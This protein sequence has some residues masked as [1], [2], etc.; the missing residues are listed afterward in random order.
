[1][2]FIE[3]AEEWDNVIDEMLYHLHYMDEENVIKELEKD[4]PDEWNASHIV[5]HEIMNKHKEEFFIL[6][7][8]YFYDLWD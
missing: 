8:K 5:V 6:F 1:M 7:S 3:S 4:V 2:E